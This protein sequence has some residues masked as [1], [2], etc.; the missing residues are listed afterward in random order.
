MIDLLTDKLYFP[1]LVSAWLGVCVAGAAAFFG[2]PF[3]AWVRPALICIGSFAAFV[4]LVMLCDKATGRAITAINF[5]LRDHRAEYME[6]RKAMSWHQ[7][8]IGTDLLMPDPQLRL[9]FTISLIVML[10]L[11]IDGQR[12]PSFLAFGSMFLAGLMS[13]LKLKRTKWVIYLI[14][15]E[16]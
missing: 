15:R 1:S 3:S 12:S 8:L 6:T 4:F 16:A 2:P 11:S 13:I 10:T 7:R 5:Y 9:A 14:G